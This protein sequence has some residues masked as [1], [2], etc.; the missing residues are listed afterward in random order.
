LKGILTSIEEHLQQYQSQ[1]ADIFTRLNLVGFELIGAPSS[2]DY[3]GYRILL[4]EA[5]SIVY[6]SGGYIAAPHNQRIEVDHQ[7][8]ITLVCRMNDVL[9]PE[10]NREEYP[11]EEK[12]LLP[13]CRGRFQ[14][15]FEEVQFEYDCILKES[16]FRDN[17]RSPYSVYATTILAAASPKKVTSP[18]R[19][20][21]TSRRAAE[22]KVH[23]N[24]QR[25]GEAMMD[26]APK[27][28]TMK[29]AARGSASISDTRTTLSAAKENPDETE[30]LRR[31]LVELKERYETQ[32][33]EATALKARVKEL[34]THV[35]E[36][37]KVQDGLLEDLKESYDWEDTYARVITFLELR[38]DRIGQAT[39]TNT[40]DAED[41]A[42]ALTVDGYRDVVKWINKKIS[43]ESIITRVSEGESS[44]AALNSEALIMKA[45]LEGPAP[46]LEARR[47]L[48]ELAAKYELL[49]TPAADFGTNNCAKEPADEP[50][51]GDNLPG[52]D[53]PVLSVATTSV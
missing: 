50:R 19:N 11:Y 28:P 12:F 23:A 46:R 38:D 25:A 42:M 51:E 49:L 21:Q 15:I 34:E 13:I 6:R 52:N 45:I 1:P 39:S 40:K 48:P 47:T 14:A 16:E 53:L 20:S 3:Y 27:A 17:Y 24:I 2:P 26:T 43:P 35:V 4:D 31:A 29:P 44:T 18:G 36:N 30:R 32:A 9:Y 8:L 22:V 33:K 41:M 5:S 10:A 7:R 37:G